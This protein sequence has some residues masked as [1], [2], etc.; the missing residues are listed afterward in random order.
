[1]NHYL[2]DPEISLRAFWY[3]ND[4]IFDNVNHYLVSRNLRY[5]NVVDMA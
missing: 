1:M 5:H 4:A 3:K 2:I